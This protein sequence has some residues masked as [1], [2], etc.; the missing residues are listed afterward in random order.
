MKTWRQA[1]EHKGEASAA[2]LED[3]VGEGIHQ[4]VHGK[5]LPGIPRLLHDRAG[6]HVEHLRWRRGR[7]T[8]DSWVRLERRSNQSLEHHLDLLQKRGYQGQNIN[9]L[10]KYSGLSGAAAKLPALQ[11]L[12]TGC[13]GR[14]PA[15]SR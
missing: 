5:R 9:A 12:T 11:A 4:A 7:V 13:S 1:E 10:F 6:A 8:G 14:P 3:A 15:A 2:H